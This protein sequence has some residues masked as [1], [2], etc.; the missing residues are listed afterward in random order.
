MEI[1]SPRQLLAIRTMALETTVLMIL[2]SADVQLLRYLPQ[3]SLKVNVR[4][5]KSIIIYPHHIA[6]HPHPSNLPLATADFTSTKTVPNALLGG[7]RETF[8]PVSDSVP[9]RF[10]ILICFTYY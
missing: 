1:Q 10:A 9:R 8:Q 2:V 7:Q 5:C 6:A 4:K 3:L